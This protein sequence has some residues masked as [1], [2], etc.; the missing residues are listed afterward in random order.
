MSI[1]TSVEIENNDPGCN[2]RQEVEEICGVGITENE[3]TIELSVYPNPTI[4]SSKL[5]LVKLKVYNLEGLE[6]AVI[7]DG[8]LHAGEHEF[9]F[10]ASFLP[11]GIYFYRLTANG[12]TVNGKFVVMK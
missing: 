8:Y 10:D 2:T 1:L 12:I 5:E 6:M 9:D 7:I 11:P 4:T 3:N